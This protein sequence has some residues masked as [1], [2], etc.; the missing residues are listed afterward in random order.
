MNTHTTESRLVET[1]EPELR[2]MMWLLLTRPG[3]AGEKQLQNELWVIRQIK[4]GKIFL[5]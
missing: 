3:T 1:G 5:N 2:I 4:V